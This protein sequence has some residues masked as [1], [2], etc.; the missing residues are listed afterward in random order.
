VLGF[1]DFYSRCWPW[2][3]RPAQ[4][5]PGCPKGWDAAI[6][7]GN[8]I[9]LYL[10]GHARGVSAQP[11]EK[12]LKAAMGKSGVGLDITLKQPLD[13]VTQ[14]WRRHFEALEGAEFDTLDVVLDFAP[15]GFI[16]RADEHSIGPEVEKRR[17]GKIRGQGLYDLYP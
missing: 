4:L 2:S 16:Y 10:R 9:A 17:I 1:L 8:Q 6:E 5:L 15:L 3:A 13:E 11:G 14:I 7:V 12:T